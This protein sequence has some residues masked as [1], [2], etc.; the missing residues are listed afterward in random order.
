MPRIAGADRGDGVQAVV[1]ALQILDFIARHGGSVG[2]TE[3]AQALGTSKSRI[4]RHLRTFVERRY[5]VQTPDSEKYRI[6]SRMIE[7][8]RLIDPRPALL[9]AS[10][11]PMRE[12]RDGLGHSVV[13]SVSEDDGL[14][15]LETLPGNS[16]VE[17]GFKPG[18]ILGFHSSAQ[19]KVALAFGDDAL[20]QRV[21]AAPMPK[22]TPNTIDTASALQAEIDTVRH[23]GW[24]IAPHETLLGTNALSAPIFAAGGLL[25]GTLAIIDSIQHIEAT[26]S[27]E[28]IRLVQEAADRISAALNRSASRRT[29]RLNT[30][31]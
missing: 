14:C 22:L 3:L 31:A 17:F 21:L 12:L 24:A 26:P 4:Y 30:F 9:E 10:R 2:V 13:L 25:A 1:L 6:G 28:Q 16:L 27:A 15:V 19:G 20:R 7:I 23:Q 18:S 8:G 11:V 5:L 29:G